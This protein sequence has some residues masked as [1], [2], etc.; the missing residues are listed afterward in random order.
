MKKTIFSKLM[1][2]LLA[3]AIV[4]AFTACGDNNDEP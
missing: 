2:A 1:P 4:F 3:A